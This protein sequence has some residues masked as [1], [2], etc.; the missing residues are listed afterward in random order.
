MNF[1]QAANGGATLFI[2]GAVATGIARHLEVEADSPDHFLRLHPAIILLGLFIVVFRIKTSLD[3]HKHFGEEHQDQNLFRYAGFI[4]AILSWL[5]WGIA[6]YLLYYTERSSEMMATS[7]LISTMWIL[8]HVI[9]MLSDPKRRKKEILTSLMRQK[10]ALTN[11]LY[12]LCLV[13]HSGWFTPWLRV[14]SARPLWILLVLLMYDIV[15]SGTFKDL[16]P[17]PQSI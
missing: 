8:V 10:W 6:A 9:E 11:I 5:F 12:A 16:I 7:I 3:D 17:R 15:T 4:L 1:F 13:A 14:G 2:L